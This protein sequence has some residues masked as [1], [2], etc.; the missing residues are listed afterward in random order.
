MSFWRVA[1]G[2]AWGEGGGRPVAH[3][4]KIVNDNE[5]KFDGVVENHKLTNLV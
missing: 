4:S 3:N 2:W 1:S 5:M